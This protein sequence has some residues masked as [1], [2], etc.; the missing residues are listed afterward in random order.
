MKFSVSKCR[1]GYEKTPNDQASAD[2]TRQGD[3]LGCAGFR[4]GNSGNAGG[5]RAGRAGS[6]TGGNGNGCMGNGN[7]CGMHPERAG[8]ASAGEGLRAAPGIAPGPEQLPGGT[9]LPAPL[10]SGRAGVGKVSN[11]QGR[12][13]PVFSREQLTGGCWSRS[14][15]PGK[16]ALGGSADPGGGRGGSAAP[17]R[18]GPP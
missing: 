5:R 6:S 7:G 10:C 9:A 14:P 16:D 18:P 15:F 2:S 17:L 3:T 1:V 4:Q 11:A 12:L 13:V 8:P